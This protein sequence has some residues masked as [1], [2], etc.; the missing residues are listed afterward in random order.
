ML[1]TVPKP[2]RLRPAHFRR[3]F[4][5]QERIGPSPSLRALGKREPLDLT[6]EPAFPLPR[7]LWA[8]DLKSSHISTSQIACFE[9]GLTIVT[10]MVKGVDWAPKQ[11][12]PRTE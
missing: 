2:Q 11:G 9:Q 6:G 4:G 3:D 10:I 7:L 5:S 12:T 1:S 8:I